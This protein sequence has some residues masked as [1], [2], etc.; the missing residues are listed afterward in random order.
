MLQK[1]FGLRVMAPEMSLPLLESETCSSHMHF[2]S[3]PQ[4]IIADGFDIE[5]YRKLIWGSLAPY[6]A[7]ALPA[8]VPATLQDGSKVT[9]VP[10]H[11]PGHCAD[12]H[13][14][15]VPETGWL[16]GADIFLTTRPSMAFYE[17]DYLTMM[18]SLQ[19]L[20]SDPNIQLGTLFCAHKGAIP[21]AHAVL[22]AKL[23]HLRALRSRL[24]RLWT[25]DTGMQRTV[26]SLTAEVLGREPFLSH[27]TQGNFSPTHLVRSLLGGYEH[28]TAAR[29]RV[30]TRPPAEAVAY[31]EGSGVVGPGA[32]SPMQ[33]RN[34][35]WLAQ[36]RIVLQEG[37][38]LGQ[39]PQI[40]GTGLP[41]STAIPPRRRG[42][43]T[44]L[45]ASA[46]SVAQGAL[47]ASSPITT[48]PAAL[49]VSPAASLASHAK[50]QYMAALRSQPRPGSVTL[51]D[52]QQTHKAATDQA[53]L[54]SQAE[55][56]PR[57]GSSLVK[58]TGKVFMP[59]GSFASAD[60]AADAMVDASL[61][62]QAFRQNER[63]LALEGDS[64]VGRAFARQLSRSPEALRI[65]QETGV[66]P[67]QS[68]RPRLA[69]GGAHR[70]QN[71][72]RPLDEHR[73]AA[74]LEGGSTGPQGGA[75][76]GE[77]R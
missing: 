51:R 65:A 63:R 67:G 1:E 30:G 36:H 4:K 8:E 27:F 22:S 13:V 55:S 20:L 72:A 19:R 17:E 50:A 39:L 9:L 40:P 38:Q 43:G 37:G 52:A 41:P 54:F 28:A 21:D 47:Q 69:A 7:E 68:T 3:T 76:G 46:A 56:S 2:D 32:A 70:Q 48:A 74:L 15:Y 61:S 34:P 11:T 60:T 59:D 35:K 23:K 77:K 58:N 44:R 73:S 10:I 33:L 16:F 14:I 71:E 5:W 75:D 66:I 45:P 24:M 62:R 57:W 25:D 64:P 18:D 26:E 49:G 31:L 53:P 29:R 12:H 42:G 6:T